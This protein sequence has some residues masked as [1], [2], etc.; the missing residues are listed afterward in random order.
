[1]FPAHLGRQI[2]DNLQLRRH[3]LPDGNRPFDAWIDLVE[4]IQKE[5]AQIWVARDRFGC[6]FASASIAYEKGSADSPASVSTQPGLM[7]STLMPSGASSALYLDM[8]KFIPAF[9]AP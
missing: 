7:L 4:G 8:T 2:L 5:F 1:M 6:V 9:A 3:G